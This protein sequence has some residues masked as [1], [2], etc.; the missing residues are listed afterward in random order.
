MLA[1]RSILLEAERRIE[2]GCGGLGTARRERDDHAERAARAECG[3]AMVGQVRK[4]ALFES[5]ARNGSAPRNR[6]HLI[7]H[8]T[9]RNF[10]EIFR[11]FLCAPVAKIHSTIKCGATLATVKA[12]IEKRGAL[13]SQ[14]RD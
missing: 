7:C 10:T 4:L 5:C 8:R 6:G 13:F 2:R 1:R 9:T 3:G 14:R 12:E 11:V